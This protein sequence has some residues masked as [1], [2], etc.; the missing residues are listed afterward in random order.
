MF[1]Q[2]FKFEGRIRRLEFGLSTL[3][4]YFSLGIVMALGILFK[5]PNTIILM[6]A[7]PAYWFLFAQGAK[8]CH[9][10]GKNGWWQLIPFYIFWL[11][12]KES[13]P[14]ENEYGTN[15]KGIICVNGQLIQQDN[16]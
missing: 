3:I 2:P 7:I 16:P 1:K 6:L 13:V 10:F 9:D 15:P 4:W 12:F 8:R 11:I 14:G 5:L